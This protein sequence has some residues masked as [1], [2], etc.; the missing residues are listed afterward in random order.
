[1]KVTAI[2]T[3]KITTKDNDIFKILDTYIVGLEEKSV[4]AI[5]SKIVSICEGRVVAIENGNKDELIKQESQWY[6]PR[7]NNKYNVSFAINNNI[8]AAGAGIDE[9]NGNGYYVLWPKNPQK[10]ANDIRAFLRKKFGIR[11]LGVILTD[12]KTTPLRWG[13]TGIAIAH[14]GFLALHDYIGAPDIFGR[15]FQ[16]EKVNV[17]DSLAGSCVY[18]M[19]EGNEQTPLSILEDIPYVQF[20]MTDPSREELEALKIGL[21]DDLYGTFLKNAPWKKGKK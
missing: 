7:A 2:K 4:V 14:S 16:Y 10:C 17:M 21:E 11:N 5:T 1:M 15:P 8:L 20:S 19:G 3:H 13:V 9:S 6:L 18:V 12:S